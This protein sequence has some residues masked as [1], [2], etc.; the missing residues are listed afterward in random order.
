[1]IILELRKSNKKFKVVKDGDK[2][3]IV[4]FGVE[5][6]NQRDNARLK[7]FRARHNLDNQI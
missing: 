1:M 3:K 5:Y 4:R 2:V 6:V 7:N